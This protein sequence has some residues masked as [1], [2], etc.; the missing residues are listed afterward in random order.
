MPPIP[1][2]QA[3][4]PSTIIQVVGHKL[5]PWIGEAGM[6]RGLVAAAS[7]S[8]LREAAP[9]PAAIQVTRTR[10][11]GPR[12]VS[13]MHFAKD[14]RII[15]ARW[16]DDALDE[17]SIPLLG[18]VIDG[19]ADWQQADYILHVPQGYFVV[20]PPGIPSPD[21]TATHIGAQRGKNATCDILWFTPSAQWVNC[22]ICH[23][24]GK[25]HWKIPEEVVSVPHPVANTIFQNFIDEAMARKK[26]YEGVCQGLLQAFLHLMLRELQEGNFAMPLPGAAAAPEARDER[27]PIRLAQHYMRAHLREP[28]TVERVARAVY[29]SRS[30]FARRFP[31]EAG[32]TFVA[33]LTEL[34]LEEAKA[35]LRDTDWTVA[36]IGIFVGLKA[37]QLHAIFNRSLGMS[38]GAYRQHA[39]IGE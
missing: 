7:H 34:R 30:Q 33:F 36:T 1:K 9:L 29:M 27:D 24:R 18:F 8:A 2:R 10:L 6:A 23:S 16:R 39:R 21:G 15:A 20:T 12:V 22:Y 14:E 4:R 25:E 38:P 11:K 19:V 37:T 31:A 5:I 32:Q 13:R 35:L 28:L 26:G 17:K 3:P